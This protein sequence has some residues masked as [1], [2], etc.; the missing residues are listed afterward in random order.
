MSLDLTPIF[1]VKPGYP[2]QSL[3][4]DDSFRLVE[5]Q[6]GERD[7]DSIFVRLLNTRLRES[8]AY[9]ALSYTW[10]DGALTEQI[11]V[12]DPTD[13]TSVTMLITANCYAALRSLRKTN[14]P[15]TLWIDSA[16]INQSLILE[17]NHQLGLM[18]QIYSRAS[19]VIVYLGEST[20]ESDS[21]MD[22]IHENDS[23]SN[24]GGSAASV[25]DGKFQVTRPD[26]ALID[27]FLQRP[28]FSRVWVLQEAALASD[29]VVCCGN[30]EIS[31]ESFRA[32]KHWNVGAK[33]VK[34]L[35]YVVEYAMKSTWYSSGDTPGQRL[36]RKL[37][38][39]RHCRATD[40]RDKLFAILPLLD[41]EIKNLARQSAENQR[42]EDRQGA[43][44][45]VV[46]VEETK[47]IEKDLDRSVV[48]YG[49]TP[50][51]VFSDLAIYLLDSV[52]PDILRETAGPSGLPSLP[53]W[54][55]DWSIAS[56][57]TYKQAD[58][59]RHQERRFYA[60]FKSK[61][62]R[63][64]HDWDTGPIDQ[65]KRCWKL[66]Q[67]VTRSGVRYHQL[68][69]PAVKVGNIRLLG[70]KCEIDKN[71]F[72]LA[73]WKSLVTGPE[74]LTSSSKGKS[75]SIKEKEGLSEFQRLLALD[76]VVYPNALKRAY[77]R[78][79]RYD[80]DYDS[81]EERRIRRDSSYK[82]KQ[83]ANPKPKLALRDI[84]TGMVP[85]YRRQAEAILEAC[86]GRRLFVTDTEH[87][88]LAPEDAEV[89]D[90]V[91]ILDGA[92]VPFVFRDRREADREES[93]VVKLVGECYVQGIMKGEAWQHEPKVDELLIS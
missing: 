78:I 6:P 56:N 38:A 41:W 93:Q 65:L 53:S 88:G 58:F 86:D 73:H 8:P 90:Y 54:V 48:D 26:T 74:L 25:T 9:E 33:V 40:P 66:S 89:G 10:G 30:K 68:E 44:R 39:T 85:S 84:M 29:V 2:G 87:I 15:R 75:H 82:T 3:D 67:Q 77:R 5:I 83:I 22:W 32:F 13:A 46:Q 37:V 80:E 42:L 35:P 14:S 60:G 4:S 16:C 57:Y 11:Q 34:R 51:Q 52:G 49:H 59:K 71:Y 55:T 70:A 79:E 72:P 36:F 63:R 23:P 61:P 92:S 28:W 19:R 27:E 69:I 21:V 43:L 20:D 64:F 76:W 17:R 45:E 50:A 62:R 1:S 12:S 7:N 81:G 24:F 47:E 18:P 31:W 91:F